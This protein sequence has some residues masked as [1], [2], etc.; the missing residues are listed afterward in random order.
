MTKTFSHAWRQIGGKDFG[1]PRKYWPVIPIS[2]VGGIQIGQNT[3][4]PSVAL[5]YFMAN[6][7]GLALCLLIGFI[8]WR[9]RLN[10]EKAIHPAGVIAFALGIGLIKGLSTGFLV[11]LLNLETSLIDASLGRLPGAMAAGLLTILLVSFYSSLQ[12]LFKDDRQ[13]LI[14]TRVSQDQASFIA[15]KID[16]LERLIEAVKR[17]L[18]PGSAPEAIKLLRE[19]LDSKIKPLS[20]ELWAREEKKLKSFDGRDLLERALFE[21][22]YPALALGLLT[23]LITPNAFSILLGLNMS[24]F[25]FLLQLTLLITCYFLLN[26]LKKIRFR[27]LV[28]VLSVSVVVVSSYLFSFTIPGLV[29][30]S[31]PTNAL[32]TYLFLLIY[33]PNIGLMAASIVHF[34]RSGTHQAKEVRAMEKGLSEAS[35]DK[36]D[37]MFIGRELAGALHGRVQNQILHSL[38]NIQAGYG[39]QEEIESV[40]A[41]IGQLKSNLSGASSTTLAQLAKTWSA[42]VDIESDHKGQLTRTQS[43]VIE[44]AISNSYRHGKASRVKIEVSEDGMRIWV[45]DDGYGPLQGKRGLGSNIFS[46]AGKWQL[47]RDKD[48]GSNFTIELWS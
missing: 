34:L 43:R 39:F 44:E 24:S 7:L 8:L 22:P 42:F 11:F 6:G 28:I 46:S 38:A 18:S 35:V 16:D 29:N 4:Q 19:L 41:S 12:N 9:S 13:R 14:A 1:N 21:Q 20:K 30:G 37:D 40:S 2:L 48:G 36:L 27:L 47:S 31:V 45:K 3:L 5:G 10:S 33:I 26:L 25:S 23:L 17:N 32:Y 15:E